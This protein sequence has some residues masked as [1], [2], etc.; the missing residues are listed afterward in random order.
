[1]DCY[2]IGDIL[3]FK[4]NAEFAKVYTIGNKYRVIYINK[5]KNQ[6]NRGTPMQ[7]VTIENNES[8]TKFYS[9]DIKRYFDTPA[10]NRKRIINYLV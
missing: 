5:F 8:Y 3:I 4:G 2:K 7:L 1:M 10:E 9:S 6:Y